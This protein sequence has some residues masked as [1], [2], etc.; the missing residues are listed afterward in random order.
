MILQLWYSHMNRPPPALLKPRKTPQQTRSAVTIEAIH[1]ATIQVLLSGGVGRLTTTRV[2]ERAGV[3]VGTM[4]QYYPHKQALLFALVERQFH[5]IETAMQDAA[6]QLMGG[7]LKTIA[8][9]VAAA[10]LDAKMADMVASRAI[11]GIAA[12]FD[13]SELL[14]RAA[15]CMTEVIDALLASACDAHIADRPSVAFM[16]AA[17]LGGSVR[18][19]MEAESSEENFARLRRELPQACHAYLMAASRGAVP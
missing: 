8:H 5:L 19:V 13:L 15:R 2:A 11:Y 17:L 6:T 16:L 7:D 3:S 9:G 10:W 4:Y 18:V 12:E 14:S 1:L